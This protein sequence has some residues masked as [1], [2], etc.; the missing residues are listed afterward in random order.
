MKTSSFT[1]AAIMAVT[2]LAPCAANAQGLFGRRDDVRYADGPILT[3]GGGIPVQLARDIRLRDLYRLRQAGKPAMIEVSVL[4][5]GVPFRSGID[6]G[7]RLPKGYR[8]RASVVDVQR[9]KTK[10]GWSY[11]VAI[12]F[13][14]LIAPSGKA[15]PFLGGMAATDPGSLPRWME[16]RRM[17][18]ESHASNAKSLLG[19]VLPWAGETGPLGIA[20]ASFLVDKYQNARQRQIAARDAQ[21]AAVTYL[22]ADL[23]RSKFYVVP[24]LDLEVRR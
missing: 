22:D 8:F 17:Q 14:K 11:K 19:V 6:T 23:T 10:T 13:D 15:Q 7:N 3:A 5:S 12:V 24:T 2:T 21:L 18:A 4:D 1:L 9:V 20:A 16:D